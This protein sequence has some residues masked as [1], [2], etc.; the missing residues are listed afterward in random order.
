MR[1]PDFF[2]IGAPKC[3]TTSMAT[4]LA[5]HP[6]VFMSPTKEPHYFN[7]DEA[8]Y[9]NSLSGYEKLFEAA[10]AE[11]AA[12]GEASVWYLY[13]Q[14]AV[15]NVL[16]YQ[17]AARFIV[18]LRNPVEMAVSLHDEMIF[19]GFETIEDFGEAWAAQADRLAGKAKGARFGDTRRLIYAD[20]CKLGRQLER[21][22]EQADRRRVHTILMDDIRRDPRA[23]YLAT[24]AF[25]GVADDGRTDFD[26]RNTAKRRKNPLIPKIGNALVAAKRALGI[27]RGFG[28]WRHVEAGNQEAVK[29]APIPEAMRDTLAAHFA[30]DVALLGRLIGRDLGHWTDR[31]RRS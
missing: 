28:L 10:G 5:E 2:I 24:L 14:T 4:W 17:P 27:E 26:A 18:M 9:I 25:L 16:A 31:Q 22:L 23:A 1:K 15:A 19:G 20:A 8:R 11:H 21:V 12:V 29:R 13:S 30:D 6:A 3:G 7:T